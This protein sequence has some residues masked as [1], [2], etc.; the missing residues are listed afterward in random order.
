MTKKLFTVLAAA[1]VASAAMA[2]EVVTPAFWSEDFK[3]MAAH[4]NY[5]TDGWTASGVDATPIEKVASYFD[6]TDEGYTDYVLISLGLNAVPF[7]CTSFIPATEGDQWLISPEIKVPENADNAVLNFTAF[8][9][10]S[11]GQLGTGDCPFNVLVS[12]SGNARENFTEAPVY[13]GK[14]SSNISAEFSS[15]DF[16]IPVNGF[17]GKTIHLAFQVT[18][19]DNGLIGF[20]NISFGNYSISFTNLTPN[21]GKE[22]ESYNLRTNVKIKA[23][24]SCPGINTVVYL[25]DVKAGENYYKKDFASR[26]PQPTI[27]LI[28]YADILK[29]EGKEPLVYRLEVTPDYE[30]APTSSMT[31]SI[32][33]PQTTYK[34]NVVV[35][36][37]TATGC[38]WCPVGIESLDYYLNNFKGSDEAGKAI[39][40][41]VHGYVNHNDPMSAGVGEYLTKLMALN[42]GTGYPGAI[43]NR[44]TRGMQP[45]NIKYVQDGVVAGSNNEATITSVEFPALKDGEIINGK[46]I[47]V[48]FNVKNSYTADALS[49]TA[50]AV[51]IENGV[52]GYTSEYSQ[53]NTFW[54]RT[55]DFIVKNYGEFIL[56][57][58]RKWLPEGEFGV[59][60][61]SFEK[62]VYNHVARG[63]YPDF[64]GQALPINWTADEAQA[65]ELNF[66]IP[67][68]SAIM[69]W[70][71][72]EIVL[73]VLDS[74]MAIV[75]S[76]IIPYEKYTSVSG[77]SSIVA[78]S[79]VSVKAVDDNVVVNAPA[80]CNVNLY[81]IDGRHIGSY[82]TDGAP[83]SIRAAGEGLVIVKVSGA[84]NATAKFNF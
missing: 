69:D 67:D 41:A 3:E 84:A 15:K 6:R 1:A 23:P 47:K 14:I 28:N 77:V 11:Y 81:G 48:K 19:K 21:I 66:T 4:H 54:T 33:I 13:E 17:G 5:L 30:G 26:N 7:T 34:N 49:L 71:N 43:F 65:A 82:T 80:D 8:S 79:N 18:G 57:S 44:A 56:P 63:I 73:L 78:D 64:S 12:T 20:S 36:E 75:A 45:Q 83:L 46:D 37:W 62:M 16:F 24:V 68:S 50:A 58:M 2:D 39:C 51:I 76:D 27:Q 22:G 9:Y 25:N 59:S 74:S 61:V 53:E 70:K 10:T 52:R 42:D 38:A 29:P 40:I 55:E 60:E 32:G 35:E 31:G 72:T